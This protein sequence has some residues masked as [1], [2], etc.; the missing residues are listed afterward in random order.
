MQIEWEL[1]GHQHSAE[2]P[3]TGSA[4]IGRAPHCQIV[5]EDRTVSRQ[6]AE[7]TASG[8]AYYVRNLS[9]TNPVYVEV[10]GQTTSVAFNQ[11]AV[12]PSG[13]RL[14]L[15]SVTLQIKESVRRARMRCPGPC[16]QIVE[17]TGNDFCP[18]CGAA[19]AAAETVFD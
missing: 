7:I 6:H 2:L 1:H 13:A 14:Y 8:P 18:N 4:V 5:V 12:L 10:A 17:V 9:Q 11:W 3:R 15:G 16:G 19:L